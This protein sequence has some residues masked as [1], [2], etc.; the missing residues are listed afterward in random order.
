MSLYDGNKTGRMTSVRLSINFLMCESW[1]ISL[2]WD[3]RPSHIQVIS[4][5]SGVPDSSLKRL[6]SSSIRPWLRWR[7]VDMVWGSLVCSFS[8]LPNPLS[9]SGVCLWS[10]F[11]EDGTPSSSTAPPT[12]PSPLVTGA[13]GVR[14]LVRGVSSVSRFSLGGPSLCMRLGW[15]MTPHRLNL[16][17]GGGSS[18]GTLSVGQGVVETLRGYVL[19]CVIV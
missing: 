8:D 11:S 14:R 4:V 15:G 13:C 3:S 5:V 19:F 7:K 9:S 10:A 12:S 17:G 18:E 6:V 16:S 1:G 2:L